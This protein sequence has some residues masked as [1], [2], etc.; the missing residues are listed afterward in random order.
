MLTQKLKD[1]ELE[2]KTLKSR[3]E[4]LEQD[5]YKANRDKNEAIKARDQ[6]ESEVKTVKKAKEDMEK[7]YKEYKEKNGSLQQ[8]ID[9]KMM[10]IP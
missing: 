2:K 7:E 6:L 8:E 3:M 9:G 5:L 10:I 1:L 4:Q